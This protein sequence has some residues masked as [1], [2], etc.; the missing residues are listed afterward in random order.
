MSTFSTFDLERERNVAPPNRSR[1]WRQDDDDM[2]P[3]EHHRSRAPLWLAILGLAGALAGT[4]WYTLSRQKE[5][6]DQLARMRG[7]AEELTGVRNRVG[8]A[9]QRIE[10]M[11]QEI[12]SVRQG[13]AAMDQRLTAALERAGKNLRG[14]G[15]ALRNEIRGTA[16]TQ[17]QAVQARLGLLETE[18][19][20][21]AARAAWL[22]QQV[23]QLNQRLAGVTEDLNRVQNAAALESQQLRAEIRRT[24]GRVT[25]VASFNNR[26]R[27]RFEI[28]RGKTQEV[29]PGILLHITRVD[30]RYRRFHG[31]LQ[32]VDEGKILWLRDQS[33]LQTFA[34]VAGR[35]ALRHDLVVTG[36][37][38]GGVSGYLILPPQSEPVDHQLASRSGSASTGSN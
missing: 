2:E 9:E 5:H 27:E 1:P 20:S 34:F 33:V 4:S 10:A 8:A 29:A 37:T 30:P 16:E 21:E 26:P 17:R 36:L 19:Q 11:P 31:W 13:V 23:A 15:V 12:D 22:E 38:S 28:W 3:P 25:Q 32:L 7:W 24:D 6:G 35:N 18:R 14:L